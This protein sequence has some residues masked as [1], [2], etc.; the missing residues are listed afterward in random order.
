MTI[1]DIFLGFSTHL[2]EFMGFVLILALLLRY[3]AFRSGKTNQ[4]YF[5]T[6]AKSVEKWLGKAEF[7]QTTDSLDQWIKNLLG[8]VE[9]DLPVRGVR[10]QQ[11]ALPDRVLREGKRSNVKDFMSA[12]RNVI[13]NMLQQS[14]ALR[15]PHPPNFSELSERV[16]NQDPHWRNLFGFIPIDMLQRVLGILPGLF[17]IGGIFGTFIGITAALPMIATIDLGDLNSATPIL[18]DFVGNISY[19]MNTSIAGIIFSVVLTMLNTMFPLASVRQEIKN[20]MANSFETI[21]HQI[22][23]EKMSH[24]ERELVM[25]MRELIALQSK[26]KAS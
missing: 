26:Q 4:T 17:I 7:R 9:K 19:S 22:H 16:L 10:A 3:M 15:N 1:I 8:E 14:D 13:Y 23:N 24:G 5:R 12:K 20:N 2:I 18:N 21:W 6:L 25:L 11:K